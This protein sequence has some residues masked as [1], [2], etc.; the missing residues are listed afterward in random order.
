MKVAIL[1]A[2]S[3]GTAIANLLIENHHQVLL[4]SHSII[5]LEK[6]K[7]KQDIS[8]EIDKS[9]YIT[10]NLSEIEDYQA[11]VYVIPS[12]AFKGIALQIKELNFD[13]KIQIICTKGL[14]AKTL[15]SGYDILKE[16]N[17]K[18]DIVILS[19]PTHAEELALKKIT[20]IVST[21]LNDKLACVVQKMFNNDYLRV[22]TQSD[23]IGVEILGAGK[24]VLAIAA[25]VCDSHPMLGDNTKAA[26]LTRG[27]QELMVIGILEGAKKDTFYG[28]TGLGDLIVTANSKHSRNRKF[29]DLIGQ[30]IE[31]EEALNQIKM[32][33][34]GLNSIEAMYQLV[35]KYQLESPIIRSIYKILICKEDI[36]QV[37]IN[38]IKTRSLKNETIGEK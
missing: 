3:F 21:S 32:V 34:E 37:I 7:Y 19:G 12:T 31:H 24:N 5:G 9:I 8:K 26:L 17:F 30:G 27:L 29:G 11:I 4:W 18:D 13:N 6:L 28:L 14:D 25:G 22:Y 23:I 16:L 33:V 38:L 35:E 1:G 2:G 10:N 20:T 36:N 15:K